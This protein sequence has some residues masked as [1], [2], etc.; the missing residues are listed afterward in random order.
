VTA[1]SA[2]DTQPDARQNPPTA[3]TPEPAREAAAEPESPVNTNV[4]GL[5]SN[6]QPAKKNPKNQNNKKNQNSASQ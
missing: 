2:L 6:R 1:G 5:P 4:G 3:A